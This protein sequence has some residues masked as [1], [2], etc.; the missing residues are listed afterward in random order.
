MGEKNTN[1]DISRGMEAGEP[2]GV[3]LFVFILGSRVNVQVYYMGKLV[4]WGLVIQ[5]I[6]SPRY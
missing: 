6:F 5:I 4:S 2:L 3:F 1:F